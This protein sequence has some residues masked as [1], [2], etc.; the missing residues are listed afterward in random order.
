MK[1]I[2][3]NKTEKLEVKNKSISGLVCPVYV[4]HTTNATAFTGNILDT[5]KAIVKVT[6]KRGK[7]SVLVA[8]NLSLDKL[9][10]LNGIELPHWN[11]ING[12]TS[13]T[14]VLV[15]Q[16]TGVKEERRINLVIP[17]GSTINLQGDDRLE[18]EVTINSG[19]FANTCDTSLS[20]M[21]IDVIEGVGVEE[22]VPVFN[23]VVVPDNEDNQSFSLGDNVTR[24]VWFN[25]DK[26][27]I[28]TAEQIIQTL[29]LVSDKYVRKDTNHMLHAKALALYP[30]VA[31]KTARYQ[32][33]LIYDGKDLDKVEL[34]V[35]ASGSDIAAGKNFILTRSFVTSPSLIARAHNMRMKHQVRD[36]AKHGV[37]VSKAMA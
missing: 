36:L 13:S 4:K 31:E 14:E 9:I 12:A 11:L 2:E 34:S 26:T 7:Q 8:P 30:T 27:A 5:S 33:F 23:S 19:F 22:F 10:A 18:V 1:N 28:T 15:A 21:Q 35:S 25:T 20:F 16:D 6:L 24:V 3:I 17:F 37:D 29:D 32:S